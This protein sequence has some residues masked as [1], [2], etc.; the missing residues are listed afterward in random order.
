MA[1]RI[2]MIIDLIIDQKAGG[3]ETIRNIMTTK[4][5]LKGIDPDDYQPGSEDDPAILGKLEQIAGD[6]SVSI[7]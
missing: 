7:T 1:G 3:D 6:L 2:K 5:I 4:L